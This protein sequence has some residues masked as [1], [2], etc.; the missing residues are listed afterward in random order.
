MDEQVL[1][2]RFHEALDKEPRPGAYER[3]RFAM[4][5]HPVA[6]RRR[7]A[8]RMRWSKMGLRIAA[9]VTVAVIAMAL[10]AVLVVSHRAPVGTVPAATDP[11]VEAYQVLV[12]SDY[13][14]MASSTSNHCNTIQDTGCAA[15]VVPVV[16]ALD[17]WV[18]DLSSFPTPSRYA[19]IDT[20]LRRHLSAAAAELNAAVAFQKANN[21]AGFDMAM[22]AAFFERAWIDPTTSTIAGSYPAVAGSYHDAVSLAK[23]SLDSC[24]NG[25]PAPNDLACQALGSAQT[26][27]STAAQ[28]PTCESDVQ[29]AA[30]QIQ[31]FLIALVQN[32]APSALANKDAQLQTDL[33][34]ADTALLAITDALLH[35][36]SAKAEAGRSAYTL[37]IS[38]ADGDAALA[39][40]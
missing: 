4:T 29:N 15:A 27:V 20:Q 6:L 12:S 36:N 2:D 13:N 35:G 18:A 8:F 34:A 19:A 1:F 28:A 14:K 25:T 16:A 39:A 5:N 32:P 17:K 7:P 26:C 21:Q 24:I 40:S 22:S 11:N 31:T 10:I 30:A 23:R 3:M 37:A 9:V 38:A 33:A